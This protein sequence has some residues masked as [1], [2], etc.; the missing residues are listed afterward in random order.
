M[1][2]WEPLS[3][4][5]NCFPGSSFSDLSGPLNVATVTKNPQALPI[6]KSV[7]FLIFL[8]CHGCNNEILWNIGEVNYPALWFA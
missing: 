2:D 6:H 5:E 7:Q 8:S 1:F 4:E 3:Q